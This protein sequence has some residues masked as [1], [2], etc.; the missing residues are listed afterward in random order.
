MLLYSLLASKMQT[1]GDNMELK[2]SCG[3]LLPLSSLPSAHGIGSMGRAA[4]EFVDFLAAAG[5]SWWQMLPLNPTGAGNSPYQCFSTF[6]GEPCYID[7]DLLESRGLLTAGEISDADIGISEDSVDYDALIPSRDKVL[8]LAARRGL[9]LHEEA[10]AEFCLKNAQW[11]EPYALYMALKKHFDMKPWMQW[12]EDIR[13]FTAEGAEKYTRLLAGDI[14]TVKYIQYLFFSQWQ[15]LKEYANAKGIGIIGDMPIYVALDSAEV[16]AQPRYFQLDE[17]HAPSAVAGVPPDYFSAKGQLWGNPL[18]DWDA[19][20][21]DGYGWWIRRV[22]AALKLCDALRIDHFRG[23]ESY[24]SVPAGET[25]AINGC[26]RQGPG[27]D[28]VERLTSWFHGKSFIAE[29]LGTLTPQVRKMLEESRLPGMKVLEFAFSPD[30]NSDYLPHNCTENSIC[31]TG[32]HDNM[33]LAAWIG[34]AKPEELAFAR[35]YLGTDELHDGIMR[36][37]MASRSKLF[38]AQL[39]DWLKLGEESRINTPGTPTGNWRWRLPADALSPEL[40]QSLRRMAKIYDR[41]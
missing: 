31:Y 38:I 34:C 22:D 5:Q 29:D 15:P 6:A 24:W 26:W 18:Y 30:E 8:C 1:W 41:I 14:E 40:A 20:R 19:M 9:E 32:T 27:L 39:Q 33:P 37:G 28:L 35:E 17:H 10:F 7:L 21:A 13:F 12:D 36:A 2:R 4:Y 11:L 16:W 3:I 23:L 25:T